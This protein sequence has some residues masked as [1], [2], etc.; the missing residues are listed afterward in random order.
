M[1]FALQTA[2]SLP[3]ENTMP[4]APEES[5]VYPMQFVLSEVGNG[6][7][8]VGHSRGPI[9]GAILRSRSAAVC[10]VTALAA[11][12]GFDDVSIVIAKNVENQG[13]RRRVA[14]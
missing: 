5:R 12:A 4:I 1:S 14:V 9:P 13:S 7:W 6:A 8:S 3:K 11:A 2:A 10:Y